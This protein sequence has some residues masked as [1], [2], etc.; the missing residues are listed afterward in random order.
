M[1]FRFVVPTCPKN[2]DRQSSESQP[3]VA[4]CLLDRPGH[5]WHPGN[6]CPIPPRFMLLRCRTQD[7]M[8][9]I[10]N[11]PNGA[12]GTRQKDTCLCKDLIVLQIVQDGEG[13]RVRP[14]FL[15]RWSR[16]SRI[17]SATSDVTYAGGRF[18]ARERLL[19]GDT[20]IIPSL[21]DWLP[22]N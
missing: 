14:N 1:V 17:R 11:L 16:M 4:V 22:I 6:L 21:V 3:D 19:F 13:T 10:Q 12:C 5:Y 18:R 20:M 15:G 9:R 2:N 7:A 8:I